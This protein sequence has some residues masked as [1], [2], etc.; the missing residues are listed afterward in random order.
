MRY[1]PRSA[2]LSARTLQ[3]FFGLTYL[4][5]VVGNAHPTKGVNQTTNK[6]TTNNKQQTTNNQQPTTNNQ[7]Q[8]TNNQQ[9]TT[10]NK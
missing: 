9:Q 7:Q 8:T 6:Q 2:A 5:L 3:T 10:N 1:A 4:D